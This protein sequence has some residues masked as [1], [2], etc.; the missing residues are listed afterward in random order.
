[1]NELLRTWWKFFQIF[2][3]MWKMRGFPKRILAV[4]KSNAL[5]SSKMYNLQWSGSTSFL[6]IDNNLNDG[7]SFFPA[8]FVAA[9]PLSIFAVNI[10]AKLTYSAL[11]PHPSVS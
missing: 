3:K 1:M 9:E 7:W 5:G 10:T 4:D 11:P 8:I 2:S 6:Q